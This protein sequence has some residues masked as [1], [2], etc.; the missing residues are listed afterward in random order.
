MEKSFKSGWCM[1]VK[2][3][4]KSLVFVGIFCCSLGFGM[5]DERAA[6]VSQM[7]SYN[8]YQVIYNAYISDKYLD[9]SSIRKVSNFY[10][11]KSTHLDEAKNDVVFQK[12]FS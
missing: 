12:N 11:A 7:D 10:A 2:F 6:F 8:P 4:F 5:N 9:N 1:M 3:C